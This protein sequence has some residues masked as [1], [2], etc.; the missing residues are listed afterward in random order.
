LCHCIACDLFTQSGVRRLTYTRPTSR[1]R[2]GG[3]RAVL[4]RRFRCHVERLRAHASFTV[5][6]R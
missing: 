5:A 2:S 4:A 3:A 6:T 1:P